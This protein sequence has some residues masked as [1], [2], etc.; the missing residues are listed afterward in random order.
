METLE[1]LEL[2]VE[3]LKKKKEEA[4]RKEFEES[5]SQD[6]SFDKEG[7]ITEIRNVSCLGTYGIKESLASKGFE[8]L[9]IRYKEEENPNIKVRVIFEY[10]DE[11]GE[12]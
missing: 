3:L 2:K 9:I 4:R 11:H 6:L 1:E 10:N 8:C 5:L 7:R 12:Y